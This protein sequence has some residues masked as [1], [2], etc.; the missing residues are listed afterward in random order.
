MTVGADFLGCL[1]REP[2]KPSAVLVSSS[3]P[4]ALPKILSLIFDWLG[5]CNSSWRVRAIDACSPTD[6]AIAKALLCHKCR[7]DLIGCDATP[8]APADLAQQAHLISVAGDGWAEVGEYG[9]VYAP[10]YFLMLRILFRL[11]A[12]GPFAKPFRNHFAA[13]ENERI[14]LN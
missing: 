7:S 2:T 10:A 1:L 9:H 5:A 13:D 3:A 8:V 6:V 11:V 12:G 4:N 14:E